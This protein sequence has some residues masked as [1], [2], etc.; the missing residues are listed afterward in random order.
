P[1][2]KAL[3]SKVSERPVPVL[4]LL[5]LDSGDL[6]QLSLLDE[7]CHFG[8]IGHCLLDLLECALG[9]TDLFQQ[10]DCLLA[11]DGISLYNL[12]ADAVTLNLGRHSVAIFSDVVSTCE[13]D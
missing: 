7:R 1:S 3:A 5:G 8:G 10:L 9:E 13:S 12:C 6:R 11:A 2:A 4:K